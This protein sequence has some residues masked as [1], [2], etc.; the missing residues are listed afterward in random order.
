MQDNPNIPFI[1]ADDF[2]R[3]FI[4]RN[5]KFMWF[6]GAGAS[7][8]AG[9]PTAWDIIWELKQQLFISQRKVTRSYVSNLSNPVIREQIQAH[10]NSL[11][12]MPAIGAD[13]EYAAL[14]EVVYPSESDRRAFIDSKLAG[15]KPSWGHIALASLM[16]A[17][18]AKI[19]WTTNFDA[20][21]ADACAKVFGDTG[22]LLS[23]SLDAPDLAVDAMQDERWPLEIKLHGDF[24]SR[25]LKNTDDELREQDQKLRQSLISACQRYGLIVAGYSGRDDSIM[26]AFEEAV[27]LNNGVPHGLFWLHHGN[28]LPNNRIVEL[29]HRANKNGHEAAIV[30][31][32]NFDETLR[33]IIRLTQ[34]LDTKDID[35]FS[36]SRNIKTSAPT[37]GGS[38]GFPVVRLNALPI[39]KIPHVCRRIVCDIGGYAEIRKAIESANVDIIATRTKSGVLAFGSDNNIRAVFQDMNISDFDLHTI[40][41]KR[42]WFDS[43]ERGLL[44]EALVKAIIRNKN[45]KIVKKS[46]TT[47][48]V[49]D[50][51]SSRE[52]NSLKRIV[53]SIHGSVSGYPELEWFEGVALRV[54]WVEGQLWLL[55]EPRTI[56]YGMSIE[57]RAAATDFS[58]ERSVRRYNKKINSLIEFWVNYISGDDLSAFDKDEKGVNA[59]FNVSRVTAFSRRLGV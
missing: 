28:N 7:A 30:K 13:D 37:P 57:N 31:I 22:S 26:S 25:R 56:F 58:R 2:S 9:I 33:D 55:I 4:V 14:F 24:R 54:D 46:R 50:D 23:A 20:M 44:G 32:H 19:V 12:N 6:L 17:H 11:K 43:G 47:F 15:A 38:R 39:I 29:M 48:I 53:Q 18:Y 59:K 49:P 35:S 5:N 16:K 1:S 52:W 27:S 34:D 36:S 40:E 10:I 51:I 21:M 45:L 3:R 8:S 41:R 42:L